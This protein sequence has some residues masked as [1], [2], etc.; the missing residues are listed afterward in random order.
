MMVLKYMNSIFNK[1]KKRIKY[2]PKFINRMVFKKAFPT[3]Y[4]L[5]L[6]LGIVLT[7]IYAF[8]PSFVTCSSIFGRHFCT[9]TGIFIALFFSLPGYIIS[10][11][12]ISFIENL[13]WGI[14]F[15][16]V[17]ATSSVFYYLLG[18]A[19]DKFRGKPLNAENISKIFIIISFSI[20]FLFFISLL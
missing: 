10:G 8:I 20:L 11:N 19:I 7:F 2:I 3:I 14:S 1:F 9:P 16:I 5:L 4:F 15:A 13:P 6:L 17:I 12:I 18:L